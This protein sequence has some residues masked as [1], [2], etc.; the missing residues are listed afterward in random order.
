LAGKFT[1]TQRGFGSWRMARSMPANRSIPA[2][3]GTERNVAPA[4]ICPN[5]WIG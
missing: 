4:K 5:A 2:P 3:I 1:T